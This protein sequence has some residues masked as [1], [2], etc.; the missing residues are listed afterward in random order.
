MRAQARVARR[1]AAHRDITIWV[2][3]LVL[4]AAMLLG[5]GTAWS[6]SAEGMDV[7]PPE[8]HSPS[9]APPAGPTEGRVPGETLGNTSDSQLW[10][11]IRRGVEGTVSIPDKKLGVL[12]QS[13]G[14]NWRAIRNGPVATYGAWLLLVVLGFLA[15]FFALRG[16]IKIEHGWSGRTVERFGPVDRFAHWL[17]ATSFVLLALTGLNL[18]YGKFVLMPVLGPS[19]FATLSQAGKYVHNFIAFA[20]MAGLLMMFVLWVRHNIPNRHDLVWLRQGGGLFAAGVHPPSER[21][22][23]GQKIIFWLVILGGASLSVSGIALLFPYEFSFFAKTFGVLNM[24]GL[25]LPTDLAPLQEQQF[26]Q[27]WHAIL[28]LVM[29][30][31]ILA[32]I[33]I[34][35]VGMQGAFAAMGS[36]RVDTNWAREH[37]SLWYERVTGEPVEH[38]HPKPAE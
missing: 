27:I 21:F 3:A 2:A 10:R 32:H 30:G 34:G 12:V 17:S 23:A 9:A 24:L 5:A 22:N 4:L 29:I 1:D 33:Y 35:S 18:L 37:H 28:G 38:Q 8:T 20:F 6:Q 25:G 16:R 14:E 19:L 15:L 31:V 13:Q 36:G 7:R 11:N 26:N